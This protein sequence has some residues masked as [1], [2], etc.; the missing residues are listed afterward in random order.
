MLK[1]ITILILVSITLGAVGV[2]IIHLLPRPIF[3][4]H[5]SIILVI[6]VILGMFCLFALSFRLGKSV[7]SKILYFIAGC[8]LTVVTFYILIFTLVT[9]AMQDF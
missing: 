6:K 5:Y 4:N 9:I 1:K 7:K 8:T 2:F 3:L